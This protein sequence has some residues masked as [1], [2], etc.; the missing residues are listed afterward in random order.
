MS[1]S[2]PLR[3]LES[4]DPDG[5]LR[6]AIEGELDVAV[7]DLLSAHLGQLAEDRVRIRLDL[8]RVEFI[9][10]TGLRAILVA[11]GSGR[12]HGQSPVEIDPDLSNPVRRLFE[13]AGLSQLL[14]ADPAS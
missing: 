7:A 14:V 4:R 3:V 13:L 9:D 8:S 2:L 6:L 11:V 5:A 12:E 10:S 1:V